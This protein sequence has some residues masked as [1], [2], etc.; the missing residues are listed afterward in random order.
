[1]HAWEV[2]NHRTPSITLLFCPRACR[3]TRHLAGQHVT[4]IVD[5]FGEWRARTGSEDMNLML[6]ALVD[7]E[8][9]LPGVSWRVQVTPPPELAKQAEA[10]ASKVRADA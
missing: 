1:M 5:V 2:R 6:L 9:E 4:D 8:R 10:A 3:S 7:H